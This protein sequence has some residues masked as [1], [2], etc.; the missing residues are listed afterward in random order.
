M[1]DFS[2]KYFTLTGDVDAFLLY[3]EVDGLALADTTSSGDDE[4]V[5]ASEVD[6]AQSL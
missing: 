6:I 2:W 3:K 1:R 4:A 5:I